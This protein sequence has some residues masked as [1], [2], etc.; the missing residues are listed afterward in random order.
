[1]R[2]ISAL[3]ELADTISGFK[4]NSQS[5]GFVPTMGALHDGHLALIQKSTEQNDVTVVSIFVNPLQFNNVLDL[6]KYPRVIEEDIELLKKYDVDLV[7]IPDEKALYPEQP[8][9]TINFGP[10]AERLEGKYRKIY[11]N[12][13]SVTLFL[14]SF[15]SCVILCC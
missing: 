4:R 6:E 9:V 11:R 3:S 13:G 12:V 2:T 15:F 10:L 14:L 5:I 8:K 7:F 1:M